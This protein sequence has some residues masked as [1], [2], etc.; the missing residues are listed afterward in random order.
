MG[1]VKL[2]MFAEFFAFLILKPD[3]LTRL[4]ENSILYFASFEIFAWV[5]SVIWLFQTGSN[6]KTLSKY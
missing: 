5:Y 2:A 6:L 3:L 4:K 1:A